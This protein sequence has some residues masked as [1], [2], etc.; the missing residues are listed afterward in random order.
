MRKNFGA[1]PLTL[2]QPVWMIAT[3]D[4][5]GNADIMN[6]AWGGITE[7]DEVC[8]CLDPA[9]K[10]CDNFRKTGAFTVSMGDADHVA[11]CDYLGIV[12]ASDVPDKVAKSG[13]TV[14]KSTLVNA[15]VINELKVCLEC[16]VRDIIE[17]SE[18][19]ILLK[20]QILNVSVD[21]TGLTDGNADVSKIKPIAF[22][23]FTRTYHLVG[24]QV[25]EAWISGQD[26]M[27]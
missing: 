26:L 14:T 7:E 21:E 8:I 20:G 16:K 18:E 10:T 12:S 23:P 6:A 24:E 3:Y 27:D 25:G 22:N 5:E 2:P 15:P 4:E 1:K 13:L 11:A 9:H 17:V 19:T